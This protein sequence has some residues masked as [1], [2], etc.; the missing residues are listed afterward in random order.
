VGSDPPKSRRGRFGARKGGSLQ[1]AE[2]TRPQTLVGPQRVVMAS[3]VGDRAALFA[4]H[5]P[6]LAH[7]LHEAVRAGHSGSI[8]AYTVTLTE[9]TGYL[10]AL[11]LQ[12]RHGGLDPDLWLRSAMDAGACATILVGVVAPSALAEV[13]RALV[14]AA[15]QLAAALEASSAAS[16]GT[17]EPHAL[18]AAGGGAELFPL[19]AADD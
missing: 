3:S 5:R 4:A 15:R 10:V 6:L 14:P 18:V 19:A 11:G 17:G 16:D 1:G 2:K 9:P 12:R 13:L 7:L 8:C